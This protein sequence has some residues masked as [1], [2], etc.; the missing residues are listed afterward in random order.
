MGI[1]I[2]RS[3][4]WQ[5]PCQGSRWTMRTATP[6]TRTGS[7][8]FFS[9]MNMIHVYMPIFQWESKFWVYKCDKGHLEGPGEQWEWQPQGPGQGV[10]HFFKNV[11]DTCLHANFSMGIQIL[12]SQGWQI[13]YRGSRWTM[14]MAT[15]GTRTGS[16][17]FFSNMHL[18][19]VYMPIFQWE[20]EILGYKCDKSH[21]KGPGEQWE[22]QP[23]EPGQGVVHFFKY[24][25]DTCLPP[26]SFYPPPSQIFSP[27]PLKRNADLFMSALKIRILIE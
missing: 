11:Y 2:S 10:A 27:K 19:H 17:S 7:N 3:Q 9:N 24:A 8:S 4:G 6:G 25:F 26:T 15:P 16:N 13:P 12:R 23:Q 22:W 14:R 1:R 5:K 20:S 18:I 21:V